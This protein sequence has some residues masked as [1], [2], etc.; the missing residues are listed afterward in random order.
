MSAWHHD[1]E[2]FWDVPDAGAAQ[3]EAEESISRW[4]P[5]D[6]EDDAAWPVE[7]GRAHV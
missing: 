7:I 2:D 5:V 1:G 6:G 4:R 3:R